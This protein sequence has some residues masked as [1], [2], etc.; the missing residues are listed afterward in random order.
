MSTK[1][2]IPF[3]AGF[4]E[5][6]GIIL[7]DVLRRGGVNVVTASLSEGPVLAARKTSHLADIL[8]SEVSEMDFDLILLPGGLEGTKNLQNSDLL[9]SMVLRQNEKGNKIG[10]ICAA[11]NALR[12]WGVIRENDPFTAFPTSI[13]SS[14][15]GE[16]ISQ[17]IVSH[18][19]IFTSVGP[20][21]AFEFALFLLE[22]LEGKEI[23]KKVEDGLLLPK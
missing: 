21:S 3:A 18:N 12:S 15:G 1:V 16:Y 8:L 20:G 14:N 5:M 19:N 6:E 13:S 2:L 9:K 22:L 17:R 10:A 23:R 11:P 7:A 4:E